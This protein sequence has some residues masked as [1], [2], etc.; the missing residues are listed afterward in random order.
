MGL[1]TKSIPFVP[2]LLGISLLTWSSRTVLDVSYFEKG[3]PGTHG[4]WECKNSAFSIHHLALPY[5]LWAGPDDCLLPRY[6][7]QR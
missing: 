5:L 1:H 4:E 3:R 2:L 7:P 6:L